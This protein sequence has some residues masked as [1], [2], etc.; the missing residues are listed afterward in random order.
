MGSLEF[1]QI[2]SKLFR[3]IL[4]K[5]ALGT[6]DSSLRSSESASGTRHAYGTRC[7]ASRWHLTVLVTL[8]G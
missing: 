3:Q 6:W 2:L 1:R 8:R 7:C 5:L 4:S